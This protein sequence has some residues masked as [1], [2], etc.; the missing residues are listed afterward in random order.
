[1]TA[2]SYCPGCG[3]RRPLAPWVACDI[4]RSAPVQP[5]PGEVLWVHLEVANG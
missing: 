3:S 5:V 4:T 1:M 2:P